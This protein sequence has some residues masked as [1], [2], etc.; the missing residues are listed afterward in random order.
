VSLVEL[1]QTE[2]AG[3]AVSGGNMD[4]IVVKKGLDKR[5]LIAGGA[6]AVLLLALLFYLWAPRADSQSLERERLTISEVT[7]GT[8]EDFLP[9]RARVTPL[10]T[11]FL[12]AVE[13]G[14]VE[15]KLV[16]DG[17][18]VVQGQLTVGGKAWT[19][20][21]ARLQGEDLSFVATDKASAWG[22]SPASWS[23]SDPAGW[24]TR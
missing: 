21:H 7:Q 23:A 22:R 12:D 24:P 20:E 3:A 15:Q 10:V 6:A 5:I 4:K 2:R 13:G 19:V 17:A 1:R 18:Q 14:R 9:L 11:V 16:E 8:F